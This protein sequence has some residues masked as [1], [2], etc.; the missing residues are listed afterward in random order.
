MVRPEHVVS[1]N[2]KSYPLYSGI[3]AEAHE[4]GLQSIETSLV[5]IPSEENG[6]VAI[7]KAVVRLK[8]G[9]SFEDYGDASPRNTNAKI[10][11][12]LIRMA[13][14]RAKGRALRDSINCGQTMLEELP[15]DDPAESDGGRM[16]ARAPVVTVAAPAANGVTVCSVAGC[17]TVLKPA[18]V[19]YCEQ[20][21]GRK[22]LCSSHQREA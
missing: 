15:G 7:V 18:Q 9:S 14:T 2:G 8:D 16:A 5:Q 13:S 19:T 3:L 10:A 4:R 22:M 12:A 21:L 20:R 11:T 17:G 1:L 6:N